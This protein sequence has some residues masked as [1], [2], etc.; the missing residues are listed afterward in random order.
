[1]GYRRQREDAALVSVAD[2]WPDHPDRTTYSGGVVYTLAGLIAPP[3]TLN[4]W[5][6]F[7]VEPAAGA[8]MLLQDHLFENICKRN[9][10]DYG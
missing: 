4:L 3:D 8:W 5:R 7:T 10:R 2:I 9:R 1:M 6:G